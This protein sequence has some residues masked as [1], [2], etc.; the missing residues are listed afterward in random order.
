M[1]YWKFYNV[2]VSQLANWNNIQGK[3]IHQLSIGQKI[4]LHLDESESYDTN[5]RIKLLDSSFNPINKV[6]LQIEYDTKCETIEINNS[7]T[8]D[9]L[10]KNRHAGIKIYFL[11]IHKKFQLIA[12]YTV[13]S[14]GKSV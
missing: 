10:I 12:H 6:I 9:I 7:L 13:L 14:L 1:G 8:E 3:K 11:N 5:L 2:S 4:F